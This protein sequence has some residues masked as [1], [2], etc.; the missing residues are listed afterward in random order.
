MMDQWMN[1]VIS[2][3]YSTQLNSNLLK[4][5]SRMTKTDRYR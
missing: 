4:H 3:L 1:A 2:D 5:G